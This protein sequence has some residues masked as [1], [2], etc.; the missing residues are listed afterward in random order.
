MSNTPQPL[1][2][3][4]GGFYARVD[5]DD[6]NHEMTTAVF[7][8]I[9][10]DA[11]GPVFTSRYVLAEVATLLRYK[12][13]HRDAVTALTEICDSETINLL[14]VAPDTFT[15]TVGQFEQYDDQEIS[16]IDHLSGV[17]AANHDIQHVFAFDGDFA[18]L[19]FTRVPVDTENP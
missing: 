5:D 17:L 8:A 3:D 4:T 10:T 2:I 16:F 1:F 14:P 13:S 15:Q 12:L 9:A 19:G 7:E 11:Y 18:T 6:A